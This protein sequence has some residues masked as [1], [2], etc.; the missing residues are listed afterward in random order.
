MAGFDYNQNTISGGVDYRF[1]DWFAAGALIGYSSA[2]DD[3]RD[4]LGSQSFDSYQA[5]I[6]GT[7]FRDGW[8]ASMAGTYSYQEWGKLDRN[9]ILGGNTASAST[10]GHVL[11]GKIEG[12]Y[13]MRMGDWSFGPAAELRAADY[14]IGSYTEHGAPGVNQE[15]DGQNTGSVIGQIGVQAALS[16]MIGDYAVTPQLR[17]NF[18]HEFRHASRAIVTRIASQSSTFV[19]TDLAP[20]ADNFVR[21]GAGLGITLSDRFSA[22][23]DFDSSVGRDGGE[24]YSMLFRLKGTF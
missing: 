16:T 10:N 15:V 11:G 21:L 20:D 5:A 17:V 3:L 22:L 9:V 1:N 23:V 18:D 2:N 12:G 24:D 6:Y 7:V 8:Y 19:T 4:G 14:R 13:V